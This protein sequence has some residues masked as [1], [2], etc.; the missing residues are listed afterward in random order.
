MKKLGFALTEKG[1]TMRLIDADALCK[2]GYHLERV[3][4][5][6]A[7]SMIWET[8]YIEDVPT[9]DAVPVK[10]VE[11]LLW[12]RDTAIQQLEEHGISFGCK[13]DVVAVVRCKD[14]RWYDK[15][16]V[17]GTYEPIAYKCKLHQRYTLGN[18]FCSDVEKDDA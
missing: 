16:T 4:Q 11:Q 5:N 17:S 12:E 3:Y 14:C 8:K 9:V 2:D 13:A 7:Q 10:S 6:D 1:K 18:M 15:S